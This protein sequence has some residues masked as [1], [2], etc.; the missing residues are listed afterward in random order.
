MDLTKAI[1]HILDKNAVIIFGSGATYGAI[2]ISDKPLPSGTMLAKQLYSYCDI[3]SNKGNLQDASETYIEKFDNQ[4]LIEKLR[5]LL[6]VKET[7]EYH[8]TI[9]SLPWIRYYTTNYDFLYMIAAKKK[10]KYIIPIKL[11]DNLQ[12]YADKND[13]CIHING[14]LNNLNSDTINSEF[15]LTGS[16][17]LS[18]DNIIGSQWGALFKNDLSSAKCVIILGLSLEYD[19]DIKRIIAPYP[20]DKFIFI[21]KPDLEDDTKRQIGRLG[22]VE[23]IGIEAFATEINKLQKIYKP[24]DIKPTEYIFECFRHQYKKDFPISEPKDS[25]VF[26]FY[27]NGYFVK[28]LATMENNTYKFIVG[29]SC[30][31]KIIESI[32]KNKRVIF[33]HSRLGNG[34]TTILE[35]IKHQLARDNIHFFEFIES[36]EYKIEKEINNICSLEEQVVVIIENYFDFISVIKRFQSHSLKRITFIFTARSSII[37]LKLTEVCELLQIKL[38][39]SD[40]FDI[41][42]LQTDELTQLSEIFTRS[43]LY[44]EKSRLS[45]HDKI[46]NLRDS[47]NGKSEFQSILLHVLKSSEMMK[48]ITSTIKQLQEDETNNYYN[49][50]ILT[51]V[52]RVISLNIS[53]YDINSALKADIEYNVLFR[54]NPNIREFLYFDDDS[55]TFKIR[56][57]T[58]AKVIINDIVSMQTVIDVLYKLAIYANN[59]SQTEKYKRILQNIVSYSQVNVLLNPDSRTKFIINYYEKLKDIA[60]YSENQFF[61]LQYAIACI[62]TKEFDR[63]QIYLEDAYSFASRIPNFTPFQI[64]N[65]QARLY[66][67]KIK[68]QSSE[69]IVKDFELAHRI[70]MEPIT[71]A[72]DH[73]DKVIRLFE[74]YCNQKIIKQFS[75][76]EENLLLFKKYSGEAYNRV[77]N[78]LKRNNMNENTQYTDLHIKLLSNQ[79]L[80]C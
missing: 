76:K 73:E 58:T 1:K 56:S 70:L 28:E 34:K 18:S 14:Y 23:T 7:K 37:D 6:T 31:A 22:T 5:F 12:K 55:N 25:Q 20:K 16:S 72:K 32:H 57:A 38:N 36:A 35:I 41:N 43:G 69:S 2:N 53:V 47:N 40:V 78:F 15:K 75:Y 74:Y 48:K 77:T 39:E 51:L 65:Q 46:K 64:D 61:W 4:S 66:L 80:F 17:Y 19:L 49:V 26:N 44:G 62:E 42:T 21:E 27:I 50:L 52:A 10:D 3:D 29:R 79:K 54:K 68:N 71:T 67:E 8:D 9:F 24:I 30:Y 60:W 33:L 45:E 63:S 13:I 11:S 59:Y